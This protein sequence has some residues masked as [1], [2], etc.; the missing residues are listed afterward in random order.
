MVVSDMPI[1]SV[2]QRVK[3]NLTAFDAF[4]ASPENAQRHF[5]LIDGDIFEMPSPTPLHSWLISLLIE[6]LRRIDPNG[7]VFGDRND[8][9]VSDTTILQPDAMYYSRQRLPQLPQR[10]TTAPDLVIEVASPSNT[11]QELR[12]K[13]TI[14]LDFGAA[15]VL[16]IFPETR[17][18]E[19]VSRVSPKEL[20]IRRFLADDTVDL[21]DTLPG[22]TFPM[23]DLFARFDANE[24]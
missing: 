20:R 19:A 16:V 24:G 5:E 15:L 8:L 1:T 18:L 10:L 2:R 22:L 7:W 21:T 3:V 13:A 12:D 6:L 11:V 14:Y 23:R 4:V 17:T 9:V